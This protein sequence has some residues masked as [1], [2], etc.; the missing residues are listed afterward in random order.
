MFGRIYAIGLNTFREAIRKRFLYALL[1]LV[2]GIDLF[3]LVLGEMSLQEEARVIVDV[4]LGATSVFGCLAAIILGVLLLYTEIQRRTIHTILSKPLERHEFV[5][6]KYLGMALT[7]SLVVAVFT[8]ALALVMAL[9][10]VEISTDILKA[11]VLTYIEVLVVAGI[12]VF[13]SSFSSPILSGVFSFFVWFLGRIT[14]E[15]RAAIQ[16]TED[17]SI[18][19]VA[20][21]ALRVVPDLHLFSVSGGTVEGKYVSV[22]S[23]FVGWDYV[24]IASG[25][26]LL[27]LAVLLTL[28]AVIFARRDFA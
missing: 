6:G 8:L 11:V 22:H 2:I 10:D 28:S 3:A 19:L 17:R 26:G 24:A 16:S 1:I 9:Q 18:E 15:I 7:L 23:D 4:G 27:Y 25:Y 14:P 20:G 21:A 5:L 12:A 13:F